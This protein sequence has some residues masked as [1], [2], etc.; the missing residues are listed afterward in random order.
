M[1]HEFLVI[2]FIE[3]QRKCLALLPANEQDLSGYLQ[4]KHSQLGHDYDCQRVRIAF[5]STD[6]GL[7]NSGTMSSELQKGWWID[8][9]KAL[10]AYEQHSSQKISI[11]KCSVLSGLARFITLPKK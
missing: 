11:L 9:L 7:S 3:Q 2:S 4:V 6:S 10:C 5:D 8:D 1:I